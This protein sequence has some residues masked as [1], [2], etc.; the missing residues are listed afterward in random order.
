MQPLQERKYRENVTNCMVL[1][2]MDTEL[3]SLSSLIVVIREYFKPN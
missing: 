1:L 2:L 3:Y